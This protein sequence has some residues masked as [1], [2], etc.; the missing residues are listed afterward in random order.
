MVFYWTKLL[1]GFNVSYE[2]PT[3]SKEER[4][5]SFAVQIN[6]GN[7]SMLKDSWN[8]DLISEMRAFPSSR[9]DD[10]VDALSTGFNNLVLYKRKR[11]VAV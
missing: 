10:Q 7:V 8:Y 5:T 2:R 6:N 11:F 3:K 1:A 9:N 4:A